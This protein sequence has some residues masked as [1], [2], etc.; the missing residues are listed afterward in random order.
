MRPN[1]FVLLTGLALCLLPMIVQAQSYRWQQSAN[2]RMEI[3]FN[4]QK[5][6]Y[7]GRQWVVLTNNSPDT[8]TQVFYHLY[9]NAFQPGSAMDVR[10]RWLPD[11]DQRV[12]GRISTLKPD[13]QGY[14]HV[15]SL[16]HN[17]QEV[18]FTEE[19]TILEV[20]LAQ[21]VL[22]GQKAEFA[23]DFK[24]QVPVQIRRSGR[25]SAEG[26]A[27]SMAQWYPKMCN[28]DEQGWH[29]NPYIAREFYGIWG[30]FDVTITIDKNYVVAATGYLQQ[31]ETIGH[32]YAEGAQPR[33][34]DG[35]LRWQFK[36]PRVHD[37]VWA[38]D[39]DYKH[40]SFRRADGT[41][42]RFFYQPGA[43]TNDN[44]EAL[45]A[46][47]DKAMDFINKTYGPYPYKEYAFIQGG[48]GGME[49][50]MATLITGERTLV[51][52]V[53]VA[54]HELM[55][56]WFQ[57]VLAS[58]ES[59]YAWMDEGF[60]S[61]AS[62]EVM[63]YLRQQKLIPGSA[64]DNPHAG[65]NAS[66][67]AFTQ[68]GK[69]EPISIHADHFQSNAA[70]GVGAYVKG[71]VFLHQLQYILGRQAFDQAM[72]RYYH[73]WSFRHPNANDFVRVMEKTG[74]LELDWYKEY[75]VNT[76]HLSDYEIVAAREGDERKQST[77]ELRRKGLMPMPVDLVITLRDDSK[78]YYTI[79]LD[80]M[81]GAKQQ[82]G[83]LSWTVAPDWT[84]T[85]ESY[86]LELPVKLNR[87]VSVEIDPSLRLV[88]AN[89]E[90]NKL[91]IKE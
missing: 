68:T 86:S 85:H 18:R 79:P 49:Y 87:I 17:G 72:L 65:A 82:D 20:Q 19:G 36:A 39:P 13:E 91:T 90:N 64:V 83:A 71:E 28:Y 33:P 76:T 29:A 35:K 53:G 4:V 24:G 63:N 27:Y 5:H 23:M 15:S 74:G 21:P 37:F 26:I 54:V 73:D 59:L 30:D 47:M 8:V 81:R 10:S 67:I 7:E 41:L 32:G 12:G 84:W 88:D 89:R 57:M 77:I 58:N 11:S 56:S 48:D 6:T 75:M 14:L 51:S 62:N 50:P 80:L 34:V 38:A 61:Y 52:L 1:I 3:D 31:P 22:P 9:F 40:T 25:Y 66:H 43:K 44:W 78:L 16:R 70:Y 46:I 55:H 69:A 2:Y 42:L 45:P 60:T